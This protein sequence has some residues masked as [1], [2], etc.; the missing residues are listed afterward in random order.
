[1]KDFLKYDP[2]GGIAVVERET[3]SGK[4]LFRSFGSENGGRMKHFVKT[5]PQFSES[6]SY[7]FLTS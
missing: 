1:M 5:K 7:H 6:T 3:R 4:T 2:R